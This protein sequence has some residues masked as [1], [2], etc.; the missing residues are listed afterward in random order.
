MLQSGVQMVQSFE[1]LASGQK[2]ARMRDMLMDIRDNIAGGSSLSEAMARHPVQFDL[3]FRNPV[4]HH[5]EVPGAFLFNALAAVIRT[6]PSSRI[7]YSQAS[8]TRDRDTS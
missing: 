5:I 3:L 2:N 7:D 8:G 6:T 1:I 4:W